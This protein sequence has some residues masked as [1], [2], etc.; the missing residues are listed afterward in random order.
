MTFRVNVALDPDATRRIEL[1]CEHASDDEVIQA[2]AVVLGVVEAL[3]RSC[4][5][6]KPDAW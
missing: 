5:G 1:E 4:P 6:C 2:R 3:F